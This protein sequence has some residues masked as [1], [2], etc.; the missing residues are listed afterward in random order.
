MAFDANGDLF[1]AHYGAGHVDVFD[2]TGKKVDELAI[3]G[4]E[5]T[6]VAFGGPGN[7]TL[8]ITDVTTA[9]VYHIKLNVAGQPLHDGRDY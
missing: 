3:P 9:S 4:N 8:V 6:N 5:P 1:V 7:T 2:P